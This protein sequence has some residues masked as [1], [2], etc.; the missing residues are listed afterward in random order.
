[1]SA[2]AVLTACSSED[3]PEP[4]PIAPDVSERSTAGPARPEV[5]DAALLNTA[6]SLEVLIIDTYLAAADSSLVQGDEIV[7]A[8]TLF[9]QHHEEH[10]MTF[11][12]AVEAAG[13]D[14]FLT[15]NPVV[16]AALVDPGL[17]SGTV[18]RDFLTLAR[19]LEHA[20]A[21][22][23][24]HVAGATETPQVRATTMSVA[25]VAAR[26]SRLLDLL[27]AL[28]NERVAFVPLD[29]PLPSDAVVTD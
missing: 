27:G 14:P 24:V 5:S 8:V 2:G 23:L 22:L 15:A 26:R 6:L 16:K 17:A 9:Q 3:D 20:S 13:G 11:E 29:N 18:E 28:G 1:M 25:G 7:A 19:D 4:G 10:R 12:A 21:Q